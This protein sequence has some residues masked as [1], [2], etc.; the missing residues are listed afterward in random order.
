VIAQQPLEETTTGKPTSEKAEMISLEF[1]SPP[2]VTA[3]YR[4]LPTFSSSQIIS[5]GVT[6]VCDA[7]LLSNSSWTSEVR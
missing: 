6:R 5:F 2:I 7:W 1:I 4:T 3:I